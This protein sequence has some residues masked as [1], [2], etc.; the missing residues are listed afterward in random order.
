VGGNGTPGQDATLADG[1]A[2]TVLV[3]DDHRTVSDLLLLAIS[4]QPDLRC[5]ATAA[6]ADEAEALT[7]RLAPDVVVMDVQLSGSDGQRDGV[8][9]LARLMDRHP[10]LRGIILTAHTDRRLMERAAAAG[11][12]CLLAKDGSLPE[13]LHA[14]RTAQRGT[15]VVSPKLLRT[16]VVKPAGDPRRVP[17]LTIR[18]QQVLAMLVQGTDTQDIAATLGI[19]VHTCRG[20]IKNVLTKLGAHSQRQAVSIAVRDGL[21][22]VSPSR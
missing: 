12:C 3:V 1:H 11:A 16:L 20:Y 19:T 17:H 4:A 13:L 22:D 18:E 9:V 5:V 7:D 10:R 21:V 8:E 2:L 14:V 15:F 6:S